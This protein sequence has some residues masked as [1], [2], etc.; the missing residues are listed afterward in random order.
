MCSFSVV[1]PAW[2][3]MGPSVWALAQKTR[4]STAL[5]PELASV[6][7]LKGSAKAKK[8]QQGVHAC[9]YVCEACV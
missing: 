2:D 7:K 6:A 9:V 1:A 4:F 3:A 5:S 8:S